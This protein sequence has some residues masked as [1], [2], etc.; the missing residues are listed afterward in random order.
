MLTR[1]SA[2]ANIKFKYI[3]GDPLLKI[4]FDFMARAKM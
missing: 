4:K 2:I 3:Q 1:K